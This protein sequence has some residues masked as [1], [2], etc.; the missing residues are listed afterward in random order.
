MI[1]VKQATKSK[2]LREFL[3]QILSMVRDAKLIKGG[4]H[5]ALSIGRRK[6]AI[7]STPGGDEKRLVHNFKS[8]LKKLLIAEGFSVAGI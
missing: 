1:S 2:L 6:L 7:S 3:K 8:Q 4:K 5:C